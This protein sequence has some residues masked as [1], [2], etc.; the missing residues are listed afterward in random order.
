[1]RKE[2]PDPRVNE[3]AIPDDQPLAPSPGEP[4]ERIE[5]SSR[6]GSGWGIALLLL[7]AV[8]LLGALYRY[9]GGG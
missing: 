9:S 8:G 1:M 4:G 5:P 7:V 3:E 2:Q 6:F